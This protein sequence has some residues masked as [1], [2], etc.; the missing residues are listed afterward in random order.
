MI[1][2][3][4]IQRLNDLPVQKGRFVLYWMQAS[5]RAEYNHALEYAVR[6]ANDLDLPPVVLFSVTDRFPE[7]NLRHYTFMLAGLKEIQAELRRRGIQFLLLHRSPERAVLEVTREAAAVITDR[8]YLRI[9]KAWRDKVA[10][11]VLCPLVQVESDVVV[12]V[13][14]ASKKEE[15]AAAT[16]RP[17]IRKL[18]NR[19]LAPLKESPVKRSSLR[20]AFDVPLIDDPTVLLKKL[21]TDSTVSLTHAYPGGTA[22]AKK[23]LEDF[24]TNKL[25]HYADLRN[26]PSADCLS[27]VSPY[28]HFGQISPLYIALSVLTAEGPSENAKEAF[29]EEMIVRRELS[30]NFVH[31]NPR[32][33]AFEALPAW[34]IRTLKE[35]TD[36]RRD[37]LYSL[38][39][40]EK[41]KTHDPYWNAA[42]M[43]MVETG[44]MHGY[45]RMYWGKKILEWTVTPEEAFRTALYLNNRYELD[46]RDANSFAGVAWCFG[47]HDRP[48]K[49]RKIF[50]TVRYMNAAGLMRKFNMDKYVRKVNS[51]RAS[52]GSPR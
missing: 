50:G 22:E 46:G 28:L 4:R 3:E 44:W 33:D 51:L 16:I 42:Q 10:Q 26:D 7:A 36:D 48:W 40:W 20:M 17:K 24:V 52:E 38:D 43:E 21:K 13:E 23:R 31:C 35:H 9:Q 6:M 1:H 45:M 14:E 11:E 27:H 12:P 41:A 37:Y 49:E 30:I 32:Y 29:L 2:P 8:G 47:K 15:Y 34:A 39:E 18:Q 5:Q 25:N 19:Y